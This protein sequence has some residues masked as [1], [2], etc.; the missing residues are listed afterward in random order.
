MTSPCL[1]GRTTIAD[2]RLATADRGGR[3]YPQC[4]LVSRGSGE[5]CTEHSLPQ[6]L[7]SLTIAIWDPRSTELAESSRGWQDDG[8]FTLSLIRLS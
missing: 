4:V 1:G 3:G 5:S 2:L 8:D 6:T 7:L